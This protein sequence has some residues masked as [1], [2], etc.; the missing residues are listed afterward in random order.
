VTRLAV[1]GDALLD[2]DLEGTAD[3]LSPD[4]PV[5]VVDDP[6]MTAR[7]GG[8]GLAALLAS[9]DG[10][11]V[12]LVTA[13]A[14][15]P[16]GREVRGL[17]ED[18]G[19]RIAAMELQGSTP[20]KI[21]VRAAGRSLLRVD[22]G[23]AG[24][25]AG[26]LPRAAVAALKRADAILVSDYGRGMAA[27]PEVREAVSSCLRRKPVVWDPHPQGPVP[28][29]GVRLA[30]PN[31]AEARAAVPQLEGE[32]VKASLERAEALA[33]IWEAAAVCITRGAGGAVLWGASD[34][35]LAVPAPR[36]HLGDPC[37][38]GDRF[39]A[40][41]ARSLADGCVVS[42]AV[43][44]AVLSASAF[45]AAGGASHAVAEGSLVS[46]NEDAP[47]L[48]RRIK[49]RGGTVVATGGCFDLLH[50]GH[51]E[52]LRAARALGDCL[53]VCLNSDESVARLKGPGRP[54]VPEGDRAAVL[55]AVD[56][57]D[58]VVVFEEDTPI[59]VLQEIKPDLF[60]KGGDYSAADLPEAQALAAWGGRAVVVP[61]LQGRST[62]RLA[63]EV[64]KRARD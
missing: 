64:V 57:V 15:D 59:R 41:A 47:A 2:R 42:E 50:A 17:L 62:S 45:I 3:R 61:Y 52:T 43:S 19:V 63:K 30:T 20:E 11:E 13:L 44:N 6:V 27:R 37:G 10:C 4:A 56:A 22:R 48:A 8:A 40:T 14:D 7:P 28:L 25:P 29:P 54:Y 55:Q 9:R 32:G 53:I 24:R 26:S 34:T 38:A 1:V 12:T 39:A 33:R 46:K 51:V 31:E 35:P 23:G 36:A 16:P 21:R 18:A 5:P 58:A 49:A 60:V